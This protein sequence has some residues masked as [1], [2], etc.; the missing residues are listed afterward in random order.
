MVKNELPISLK[1]NSRSL[2]QSGLPAVATEFMGETIKVTA[3]ST[4][5]VVDSRNLFTTLQLYLAVGI[6]GEGPAMLFKVHII[7]V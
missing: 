5:R 2:E 4:V 6:S 1:K 3:L 7:L